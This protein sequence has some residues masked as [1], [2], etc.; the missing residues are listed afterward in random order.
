VAAA[1]LAAVGIAVS[2]EGDERRRRLEDA[3]R[4]LRAFLQALT[5]SRPLPPPGPIVAVVVGSDHAALTLS[6]RLAAADLF[7][8]AIRPPTVPEGTARLRITLSADH[9]SDDVAALVKVLATAL[10]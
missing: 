6:Q 4:H 7:V 3:I 5:L 9:R 8:P 1:A 2:S 10:L